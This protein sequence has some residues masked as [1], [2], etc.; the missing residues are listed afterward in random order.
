MEEE[1]KSEE[2]LICEQLIEFCERLNSHCSTDPRTVQRNKKVGIHFDV[3]AYCTLSVIMGR[4]FKSLVRLCLQKKISYTTDVLSKFISLGL[5]PP[6][7][8]HSAIEY[9]NILR[10]KLV[11]LKE[12]KHYEIPS[13]TEQTEESEQTEE[14]E[15]TH[16]SGIE[17]NDYDSQL[18]RQMSAE[19]LCIT[20]NPDDGSENSSYTKQLSTNEDDINVPVK[21][22][23]SILDS[24]VYISDLRSSDSS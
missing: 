24:I 18:V 10:T 11:D 7:T 4:L 17:D 1:T 8:V 3:F 23:T 16:T 5:S 19:D 6:M 13:V 15:Q 9:V 21:E 22:I 2:V 12:P 14:T 20:Q